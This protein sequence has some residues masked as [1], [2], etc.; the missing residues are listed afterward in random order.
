MFLSP[1]R[2]C[3]SSRVVIQRCHYSIVSIS[4]TIVCIPLLGARRFPHNYVQASFQPLP[5]MHELQQR[6]L[7]KKVSIA[8]RNLN[9]VRGLHQVLSYVQSQRR[10]STCGEL[11]I[12]DRGYAF[13][14][15]WGFS[16][17]SMCMYRVCG[18]RY[19]RQL[20][21]LETPTFQGMKH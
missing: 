11:I 3:R 8:A 5:G 6:I 7:I 20:R 17:G 21:K 9:H 12:L 13:R 18:S 19:H 16:S 2:P 14:V 10:I 1:P 15:L 4:N